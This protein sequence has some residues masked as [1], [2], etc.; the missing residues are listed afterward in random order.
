M[1][2]PLPA[3]ALVRP[4][5]ARFCDALRHAPA[6]ID[7]ERARA[8]HAGY[9]AAL[10]AAGVPVTVLAAQDDLPDSCFVEDPIVALGPIAVGCRSAA[11]SRQPEAATL[12]AAVSAHCP[13]AAMPPGAT[14]DGGDV[15][16]VG[17]RLFVGRSARTNAAGLA[18]LRDTAAACGVEVVS[19]SLAAGLH[20]KSVV[21]L[22]GPDLLVG[23]PDT[24]DPSAFCGL[25]LLE[26]DEPAGGNVLAL[27]AVTLVSSAAPRTAA[28][29]RRAGRGVQVLAV[30]EFHKADGA[31]TC[32][33]VRLPAPG[34]WA[35]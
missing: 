2:L 9:V 17:A 16:R 25:R 34:S 18:F 10:R 12:H 8:Q 4:V 29:L 21:T 1:S 11:P 27:G 26:V 7:V 19:V 15:L 22:A 30:D 28:R 31:L 13:V 6:A 23:L 32:L 5:A 35:T 3:R 20:L 14:L 33:S 24:F